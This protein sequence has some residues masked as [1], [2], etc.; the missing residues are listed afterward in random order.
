LSPHLTERRHHRTIVSLLV[1]CSLGITAG[2][3]WWT[4]HVVSTR[5]HK[6]S[7]RT[8]QRN[9]LGDAYTEVNKRC[10]TT[11]GCI[12]GPP[13]SEV[14]RGAAGP[15]GD[16]GDQGDAGPTGPRGPRGRNGVDGQDGADGTDGV[17]GINGRNGKDGV[18]GKD[19]NDGATG[20]EGPMGPVG[21]PGPQGP[22]GEQGATGETGATG[23]AG[24]EGPACPSNTYLEIVT[25]AD[26]QTGYGCVFPPPDTTPVQPGPTPFP[27]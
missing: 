3:G 10:E 20:P 17:N 18:D 26:G 14:I 25:Y 15:K 19:G 8:D 16:Q 1:A 23:P 12:A 21:P 6:I 22:R 9:T 2:L 24:P 11:P 13:A 7:E 4:A 27:A 5:D